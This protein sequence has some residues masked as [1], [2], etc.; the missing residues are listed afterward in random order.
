MRYQR[1]IKHNNA[2]MASGCGSHACDWSRILSL[3]KLSYAGLT[4]RGAGSIF[5]A[6]LFSLV[7]S[8]SGSKI[9]SK[10]NINMWLH[11]YQQLLIYLEQR[12]R[13]S[14]IICTNKYYGDLNL[15]LILFF[16]GWGGGRVG[17]GSVILSEDGSGQSEPGSST[18]DII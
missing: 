16:F 14:Q 4:M 12:S 6:Q 9:P 18:P 7:R 2:Y 11:Q 5:Y 1:C 15:A 17:S 13:I 3:K 8:G 10:I